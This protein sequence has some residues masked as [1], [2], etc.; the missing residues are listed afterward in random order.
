MHDLYLANLV[1][2]IPYMLSHWATLTSK[3]KTS[4]QAS[5]VPSKKKQSGGNTNDNSSEHGHQ[6]ERECAL[7]LYEKRCQSK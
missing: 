4:R 7:C 5:S 6:G 3:K 1:V 2:P